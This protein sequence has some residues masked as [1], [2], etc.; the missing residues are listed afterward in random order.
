MLASM[1]TPTV[2]TL[3]APAPLAETA[4]APAA[5]I[6]AEP[7]TTTES[8]VCLPTASSESRPDERTLVLAR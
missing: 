2:L 5:A 7:A 4:T 6:A 1:I 3:L 8:I